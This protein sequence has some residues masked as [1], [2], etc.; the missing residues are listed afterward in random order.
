V[1]VA[2]ALALA[3]TFLGC[4][5]P[6]PQTQRLVFAHQPL[7]GDPAALAALLDGFARAHPE[8]ELAIEIMPNAPEAVH[9][10]LLTTLASGKSGFDVFMAD[11][12]WV[13]ELA[14]AG[15]IADLSQ[16][17][18]PEEL[19]RALVPAAAESAVFEGRS[20]G[21]PWWID[22][23]L[24]FYRKDLIARAPATY[25][26]L[27]RAARRPGMQGFLWQGRQYEGL[28]CNG[29]EAGWGHGAVVFRNGRVTVDTPQMRAG[30]AWLR[31]MIVSGLSPRSVL[32]AGEEESR[33]VFQDG[34]AL[35]M[36]NWPY[37]YEE[38][39]RLG[40]PVEGRVGV[41]PLPSL[42]G[43]GA[44]A[45]GGWQLVVSAGSPRREA[46]AALIAH[47]T[48]PEAS[49]I[50]AAAYG[51]APARAAV[52]QDPRIPPFVAML[53]PI[54]AHARARPPT[55]YYLMLSDVLQSELS[56]IIAGVRAPE[57]ALSRAQ[58]RIDYLTQGER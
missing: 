45:L 6:R 12:V 52:Y 19:E 26:E 4:S 33:R 27:E 23:G 14:R 31:R 43:P 47:L 40:S 30:L 54:V 1:R 49:L 37:A 20:W 38:S 55:P 35:F 16:F 36:R 58:K 41:A 25:D 29:L 28:V 22:V 24:L 53:G 34:R 56:A 18:P 44:G 3:I 21:V 42:E 32:S 13:P 46:A 5:E 48:S 2:V 51:R 39:Q 7:L 8:I 15:W 17:F 9:Q 50:M 57:E 10:H 11:V